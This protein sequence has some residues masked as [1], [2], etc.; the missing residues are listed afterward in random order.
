MALSEIQNLLLTLLSKIN[1]ETQY[2]EVADILEEIESKAHEYQLLIGPS[3]DKIMEE[4]YV[5]KGNMIDV[6]PDILEMLYI[7]DDLLTHGFS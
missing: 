4:I 7:V 5:C 6:K 2:D 1:E 3:V